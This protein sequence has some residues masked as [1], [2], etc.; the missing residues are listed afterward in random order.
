MKADLREAVLDASIFIQAFVKE[1]YSEKALKLLGSL[2]T[3]YAPPLLPYEA[4]NTLIILNRRGFISRED[5]LTL[6]SM[7]LRVPNLEIREHSVEEAVKLAL[8]LHLTLY[9]A[10]YI[11]LSKEL[12]LPLITADN[13][14]Y[15]RGKRETDVIHAREI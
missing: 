4:G 10:S 2:K 7:I 14:Q 15:E 12:R 3:I 1:Q 8:K 9:D 11:Q 6:S 5:A 13:T